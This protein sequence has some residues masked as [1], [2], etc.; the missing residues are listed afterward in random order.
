MGEKNQGKRFTASYSAKAWTKYSWDGRL[1]MSLTGGLLS[2]AA[3]DRPTATAALQ[4]PF[5][6][7]PVERPA[8]EPVSAAVVDNL[9]RFRSSNRFKRA[10]LTVVTPIIRGMQP[11]L[12]VEPH[13]LF[14]S[15]DLLG[16]G[17]IEFQ[18]AS[19]LLEAGREKAGSLVAQRKMWLDAKPQEKQ[20][21]SKKQ[22]E[23]DIKD[24]EK[25]LK[26]AK[27]KESRFQKEMDEFEAMRK[28][29]NQ[30][31]AKALFADHGK[32]G[33]SQGIT[34]IE[35]LTAFLD[36]NEWLSP[37][38]CQAAF[39]VFDKDNV[40]SIPVSQLTNGNLLGELSKLEVRDILKDLGKK[41]DQSINL[42][43]FVDMLGGNGGEVCKKLEPT[44][45]AKAK[46]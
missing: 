27:D 4:F 7:E 32:A 23:A 12:F 10:A 9:C 5:I 1:A 25:K 30:E 16:D 29:V 45:K 15:L 41:E 26:E 24:L 19:K 18:H 33:A 36:P 17:F 22:Y 31:T 6:E 28:A 14:Q 42:R 3:K 39:A 38:V 37:P 40:G 2:Q 20:A 21:L 43:E 44:P 35:F 34:Y 8:H 46:A 13:R 11:G